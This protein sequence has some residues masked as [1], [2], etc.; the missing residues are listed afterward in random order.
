MRSRSNPKSM[1]KLTKLAFPRMWRYTVTSECSTL[2]NDANIRFYTLSHLL[3]HRSLHAEFCRDQAC[4]YRHS[5]SDHKHRK[6]GVQASWLKPKGTPLRE[7]YIQ[8]NSHLD[9][10][11][12]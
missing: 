5:E 1:C 11:S 2:S 7:G 4:P 12:F 6:V 10:A 9:N 3:P 8:L